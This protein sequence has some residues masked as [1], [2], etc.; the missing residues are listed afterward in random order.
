MWHVA[1][2]YRY[3]NQVVLRLDGGAGTYYAESFPDDRFRL[4]SVAQD[5]LFGGAIVTFDEYNP[6]DAT[7]Y[8]AFEDSCISDV[9]ID[10][11][12]FPLET[13]ENEESEIASVVQSV[14]VEDQ[15]L[16]DACIGVQCPAGL[17]CVDRW[18]MPYCK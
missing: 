5:E 2:V 15:C 14:G 4:I 12:V 16:S 10:Q 3:G 9:R 17:S 6:D 18:K 11:N 7:V 8:E 13:A 1:L